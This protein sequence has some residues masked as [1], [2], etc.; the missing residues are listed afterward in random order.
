M[1]F[2]FISH[3]YKE[4]FEESS[5]LVAKLEKQLEIAKQSIQSL[6]SKLATEIKSKELAECNF[7]SKEY[8]YEQNIL[9]WKR[10]EKELVEQVDE[11]ATENTIKS[12]NQRIESLVKRQKELETQLWESEVINKDNITQN[13]V[14]VT[15][16][17]EE[18]NQLKQ[19]L[20]LKCNEIEMLQRKYTESVAKGND[21]LEEAKRLVDEEREKV[22]LLESK[23]INS[24]QENE[25]LRSLISENDAT[26]QETILMLTKERERVKCLEVMRTN[27]DL[28][29]QEAQRKLA[30]EQRKL[31][32]EQRKLL[33]MKTQLE[34]YEINSKVKVEH[35]SVGVQCDL[36]SHNFQNFK[37]CFDVL[38]VVH[39]NSVAK[40]DELHL[41]SA[42]GASMLNSG[43]LTNTSQCLKEE[44]GLHNEEMAQLTRLYD[45][46]IAELKRSHSEAIKELERSHEEAMDGLKQDHISASESLNNEIANLEK[47]LAEVAAENLAH[48]SKVEHEKG[49]FEHMCSNYRI[50]VQMVLNELGTLRQYCSEL[51]M[52]MA[53]Q[54][55]D[56]LKLQKTMS[57]INDTQM[58]Q[59]TILSEF[60]SS[61]ENEMSS[62]SI[63]D[64]S[65]QKSAV[66]DRTITELSDKHSNCETELKA[67]R[68]ILLSSVNGDSMT[69]EVKQS[70]LVGKVL[71]LKSEYKQKQVELTE[72]GEEI[73]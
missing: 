54:E 34:D 67:L 13:N 35:D 36:L 50:N 30:E 56:H 68:D 64:Q 31:A 40:C 52:L 17:R 3:R 47:Q 70:T 6:E 61:Y 8:E 57:E 49:M 29:L 71:E 10:R 37:T 15:Q 45:E 9:K 65:M 46:T 51:E 11:K 27:S 32:E 66:L 7:N 23:D 5:E 41:K 19:S 72:L 24:K 73:K 12:L 59:M 62:M 4:K 55:L 33:K 48:C 2:F 44:Q 22:K 21:A 28:A 58:M 69:T 26:M 60:S 38:C 42:E 43:S 25:T 14:E 53:K 63:I 16:M 1:I 18:C 20:E 39:A